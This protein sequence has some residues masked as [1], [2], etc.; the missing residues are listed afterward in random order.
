MPEVVECREVEP[1]EPDV[2]TEEIQLR[3]QFERI[4][5]EI[6]GNGLSG[7]IIPICIQSSINYNIIS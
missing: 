7:H 5:V 3:N 2:Q 6:F 4:L 1:V